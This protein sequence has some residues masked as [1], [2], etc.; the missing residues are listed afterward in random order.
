MTADLD[1]AFRAMLCGP[2]RRGKHE[3]CRG[4]ECDCDCWGGLR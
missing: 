3:T 2:C 4:R 1:A